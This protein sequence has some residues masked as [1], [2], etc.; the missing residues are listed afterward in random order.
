MLPERP[1]SAFLVIISNIPDLSLQHDEQMNL[2]RIEW[3]SGADTRTLRQSAEQLLALNREL[4]ARNLL[5]NMNTFPDISVYDQVWL[6]TS[7]MPDIVKLPLE[8][9]VLVNHRRRVHNQLAIDSLLAMFRSIIRFDI[10]YFPQP[11]PG[12]Q[13]LADYSTR[14]PELQAEWDAVYG[15]MPSA[16]VKATH[17]RI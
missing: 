14:L 7:W 2:L 12:L 6:G 9:V 4:G 16:P 17:L 15:P 3:A 10:Q 13:W 1:F 8:R 5:L 11:E